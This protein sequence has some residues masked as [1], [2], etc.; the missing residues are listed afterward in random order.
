LDLL[1]EGIEKIKEF[2]TCITMAKKVSKFIYKHGEKI[3]GDFVRSGVTRFATSFPTLA[4][5]YSHKNGLWA[6]FVSDEWHQTKFPTTQDG[7]QDENIVLS[8]QF[9][10]N[11]ENWLRASQPLF[12]TLRTANGDETPAAPEIMAAM[13]KAKTT[14]KESLK[15]KLRLLAEVL[16]YFEKRWENQMEQKLYRVAL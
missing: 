8:I 6:L 15:E 5:M 11:V 12:I 7:V 2:N 3:G 16:S 13:D 14:I 4:S 9:W 1:L 10:H